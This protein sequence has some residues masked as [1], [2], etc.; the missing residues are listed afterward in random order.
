MMNLVHTTQL[1]D[2]G[3]K[4]L[5]RVLGSLGQHHH[6]RVRG[7]LREAG[8]GAAGAARAVA[9]GATGG[10][11]GLRHTFSTMQVRVMPHLESCYVA[12]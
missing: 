7:A 8:A 10:G 4:G 5:G 2:S 6:H 3:T 11:R 12:G 1:F 9:A